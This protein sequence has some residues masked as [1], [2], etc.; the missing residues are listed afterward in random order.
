M[1]G[2]RRVRTIDMHAHVWVDDVFPLIKDRKE[3]DPALAGL[4]RS[5]MAIDAATLDRR[6]KEMDR[7]GI[8]VH[9]ISVHPSQFLYWTEPELGRAHRQDAEREG[10]GAGYGAQGSIRRVR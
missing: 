2:G 6:F 9:V 5:F 8:D 4:G 7:I 10:R 3:I 1:V